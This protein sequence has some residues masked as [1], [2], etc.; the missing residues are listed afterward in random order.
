MRIASVMTR[1]CPPPPWT[2]VRARRSPAIGISDYFIMNLCASVKLHVYS[3][4]IKMFICT[5][6]ST[7]S[8]HN[9]TSHI[10]MHNKFGVLLNVFFIS[11]WDSY[12][13]C[14][15]WFFSNRILTWLCIYRPENMIRFTGV[16][17]VT[18][19]SPYIPHH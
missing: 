4:K 1:P 19:H 2:A 15:C 17:L 3:G 13:G 7:V 8:F 14:S 12:L 6:S 10:I 5:Q 9:M 16:Y 11:I 18:Q